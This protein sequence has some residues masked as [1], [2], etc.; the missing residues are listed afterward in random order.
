MHKIWRWWVFNKQHAI[1]MLFYMTY[2]SPTV[3]S[4]NMAVLMLF[5][6]YWKKTAQRTWELL[7]FKVL[8]L[9]QGSPTWWPRGP[10]CPHGQCES[11][12][13]L[14][15]QK[16]KHDQCLHIDEYLYFSLMITTEKNWANFYFRNVF[17]K[18]VGLCMNLYQEVALSFKKVGDPWSRVFGLAF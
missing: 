8:G 4:N 1:K 2:A 16:H 18:L 9:G 11:P 12:V 6:Y 14:L 7:M 3:H 13:G 15:W 5:P 17:I 10:S